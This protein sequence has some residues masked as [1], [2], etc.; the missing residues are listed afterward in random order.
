MQ[1]H[2]ESVGGQVRLFPFDL[3]AVLICLLVNL[4]ILLVTKEDELESS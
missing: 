2:S 4:F 3:F 1:K